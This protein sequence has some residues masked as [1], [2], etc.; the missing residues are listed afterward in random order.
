M[1]R[2]AVGW[3]VPSCRKG[4]G[5]RHPEIVPLFPELDSDNSS[6]DLSRKKHLK[7][8]L[9]LTALLCVATPA[10]AVTRS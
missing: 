4:L 6:L 3:G 10:L 9:L 5:M 2:S 8:L 7:T 1:R